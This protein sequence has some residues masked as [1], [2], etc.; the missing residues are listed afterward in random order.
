MVTLPPEFVAIQYPG[1]FWN[2]NDEQLY[3]LKTAGVLRPLKKTSGSIYTDG[4]AG[5]NISVLGRRA[6]LRTVDL[7]MLRPVDSVIPVEQR[8]TKAPHYTV[9]TYPCNAASQYK[10]LNARK[11]LRPHV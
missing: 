4:F 3:S 9:P 5:Y 7:K 6:F 10:Y 8:G 2:V 11:G 1:Y